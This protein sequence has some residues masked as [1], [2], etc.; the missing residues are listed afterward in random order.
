[1][2]NVQETGSSDQV[3]PHKEAILAQDYTARRRIYISWRMTLWLV[4]MWMIL[5]F[6]WDLVTLVCG[7]LVAL[8]IQVAFPMPHLGVLQRLRPWAMMVLVGRF[9]YDVFVSG[10]RVAMLILRRHKTTSYQVTIMMKTQSQL[11][12]T[13]VG[14]MTALT[15]GT[16]VIDAHMY[17][18][19]LTLHVFDDAAF[20][21]PQ[22]ICQMVWDLE[23]RVVK[24]IGT[25]EELQQ[26]EV[27]AP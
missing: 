26:L 6:Q 21:D 19:T 3:Q 11:Y 22:Q 8:G 23:A 1:M 10:M 5:F 25:Q 18:A 24:A 9:V 17:P 2:N 4:L 16:L 7:I 14:D 15:P 12:L 13:I 27:E 20:G